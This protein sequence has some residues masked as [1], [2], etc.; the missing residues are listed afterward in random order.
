MLNADENGIKTACEHLKSGELVAIPTETVYGLAADALNE[1]AVAKI[2]VA[3]GRPQD[4]PLIV[5]IAKK[6]DVAKLA[7]LVPQNAKLLMDKFCPGPLTVIL[8]KADNVPDI[9]TAGLDSVAIR[10][11]SH[12]VARAIIENSGLMLAAPSA[13]LSGSPSPTTAKHVYNDLSGKI[14]YVVDGGEC[15]VG[16]ESTVVS[17]LE[18]KVHL[19]RPGAVTVDML[20]S[21]VGDITIDD[22]V[23]AKLKDTQKAMSPGLKYKHYSPKCKITIVHGD[24]EKFKQIVEQNAKEHDGVFAMCFDGEEDKLSCQCVTYGAHNDDSEQARRL[25]DALRK[26]DE[27]GAKVV[28]ARAPKQDA[29]GLA[30]YNRLLRAAGFDVIF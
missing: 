15:S 30:V 25:F 13:N 7:K 23:L 20:E 26:L 5:H 1:K 6:E 14:K 18:G 12:P 27:S 11:P 4:N 29:V 19:L 2:F 22:A 17:V 8:P 16:L 24:F 28:F 21:V 9:V 3:K 10:M